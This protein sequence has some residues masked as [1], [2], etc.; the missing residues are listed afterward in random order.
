MAISDEALS[1]L[2]DRSFAE[3]VEKQ[4]Q[5]IAGGVSERNSCARLA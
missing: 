2:F 4:A 1:E 3:F 5:E